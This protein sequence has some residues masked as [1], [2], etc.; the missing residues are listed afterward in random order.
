MKATY[1]L[2][3]KKEKG[4]VKKPPCLLRQTVEKPRQNFHKEQQKNK[5]EATTQDKGGGQG[6]CEWNQEGT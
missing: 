2:G 6:H 4:K 3:A 1:V 5:R